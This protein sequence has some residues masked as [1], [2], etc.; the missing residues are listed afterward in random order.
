M[1]LAM[2]LA[3]SAQGVVIGQV[4][5]GG[6]R[7]IGDVDPAIFMTGMKL[8]FITQPMYLFNICIVKLS[9]GASLLR[10]A[11]TKFYKTLILSVMGF[12][13]FYT[14]GC[15]FVANPPNPSPCNETLTLRF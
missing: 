1:V 3:L 6:G 5:Y 12:M 7:H 11:S 2:V 10:I 13:A 9:V 8:N 15:F 4:I 14:T